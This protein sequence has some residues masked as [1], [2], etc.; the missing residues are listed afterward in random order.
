MV[1]LAALPG[2]MRALL[3]IGGLANPGNVS[4]AVNSVGSQLR[5]SGLVDRQS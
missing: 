1:S 5:F 3:V 2:M 4:K